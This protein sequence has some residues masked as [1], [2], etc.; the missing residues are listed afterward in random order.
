MLPARGSACTIRRLSR[1]PCACA[2][3]EHH[4]PRRLPGRRAQAALRLGA[5]TAQREG[6]HQLGQGHR[7]ALGAAARCRRAGADPRAHALPARAARKA[8]QAQ[9]DLADRQGRR[10]HRRRDLQPHG[11]RGGRRRGLAGCAGR[12]H[13]GAH[14][15]G[16]AAPA[17]VHRQPQ[18]RRLAAVG[19]E[20][21]IDAAE[22]RRRHGA[23]RQDARHLGLRQDRPDRCRLRQGLRHGGHGVGQRIGTRPRGEGRLWGRAELRSVLRDLPSSSSMR[24]R[25]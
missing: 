9:A 15:G 12:A 8:P 7:P 22:L 16:D 18:A 3:R 23:A 25:A 14:H 4:H 1:R 10:T 6:L 2:A 24:F 19:P 20:G 17:A 21:G 11:H 5:R 13:L